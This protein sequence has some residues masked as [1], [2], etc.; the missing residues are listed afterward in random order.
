[1]GVLAK[2]VKQPG[3]RKRYKIN[4]TNWLDTG[5]AVATVDFDVDKVTT[6]PLVVDD[7]MVTPD[8]KGVQYYVSGGVA[9]TQYVVTATLTTNN[10]PQVTNNGSQVKEDEIYF[11]IREQG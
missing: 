10:G 3:E 11:S 1:M 7:I 4:Y 5:E 9:N 2:Y 8:A 6:P